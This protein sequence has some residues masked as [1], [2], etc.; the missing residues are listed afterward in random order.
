M[1]KLLS[2][3]SNN[4]SSG[5]LNTY[6]DNN[7]APKLDAASNNNL[8][9]F[10]FAFSK[11]FKP[12]DYNTWK[13][14]DFI[15]YYFFKEGYF[16]DSRGK[17]ITN[18]QT[19]IENGGVNCYI[20]HN[21]KFDR[22]GSAISV[23]VVKLGEGDADIGTTLL[24]FDVLQQL[25]ARDLKQ[26]INIISQNNVDVEFSTSVS[27]SNPSGLATIKDFSLAIRT[28]LVSNSFVYDN[29]FFFNENKDSSVLD[30]FDLFDVSDVEYDN[31]ING[32]ASVETVGKINMQLSSGFDISDVST[33]TV[34]D[35][36]I[37]KEASRSVNG[38]VFEGAN[39]KS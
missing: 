13:L 25:F 32:S 35:Y 26:C 15:I 23:K 4:S 12:Y 37:I 39:L 14:S 38:N 16:K 8:V 29:Y 9:N 28:D 5:V 30:R 27:P 2:F 7:F 33:W 1:S 31:I 3:S 19:I 6:T 21:V 36:I 34:L 10:K 11:D 22:Y 20:K 17:T 18:F 24:N